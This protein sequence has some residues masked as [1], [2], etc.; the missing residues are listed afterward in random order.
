V[1]KLIVTVTV[2]AALLV[3][4]GSVGTTHHKTRFGSVATHHKVTRFG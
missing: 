3:G 4:V 2:A 1:R